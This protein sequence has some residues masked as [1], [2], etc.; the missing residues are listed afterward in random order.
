MVIYIVNY[1]KLVK[2]KWLFDSLL[3]RAVFQLV[4]SSVIDYEIIHKKGKLY[5]RKQFTFFKIR[6]YYLTLIA[7]IIIYIKKN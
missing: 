1:V 5:Y 6:T 3:S 4:F 2:Y 7:E